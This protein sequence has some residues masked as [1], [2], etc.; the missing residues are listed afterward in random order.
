MILRKEGLGVALLEQIAE[1]RNIHELKRPILDDVKYYEEKAKLLELEAYAK[2]L[3]K[4][5]YGVE[6]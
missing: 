5:K 2:L 6:Q 3:T 4:N 1:E